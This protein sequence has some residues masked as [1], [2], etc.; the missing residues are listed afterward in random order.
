M[1]LGP[2]HPTRIPPLCPRCVVSCRDVPCRDVVRQPNMAVLYVF[3]SLVVAILL[4]LILL[5]R[6]LGGLVGYYLRTASQPRRELLLARVATE[7]KSYE[8]HKREGKDDGEREQVEPSLVGSAVKGGKAAAGWNG[9][10]G[11]FHPFWYAPADDIQAYTWL[12]L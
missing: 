9:I 12:M 6:S 10:V 5:P 8:Q 7:Q 11:F 4:A 2:G 3:L 1:K